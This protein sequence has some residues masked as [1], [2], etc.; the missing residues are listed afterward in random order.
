LLSYYPGVAKVAAVDRQLQDRDEFLTEIKARL[1]Q[2]QIV[3]KT[4]QNQS[5]REVKFQEGDWV[6]LRLQQWTAVGVTAATPSKLG[7]RFFE[8]YQ[9]TSRIGKVSYKLQLPARAQIHDVFHVS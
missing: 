1:V 7:P 8:P 3:M 4:Y 2:A 9:V 5:R 6:W